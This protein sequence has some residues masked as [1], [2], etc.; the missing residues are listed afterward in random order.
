LNLGSDF[1]SS[2]AAVAEDNAIVDLVRSAVGGR[3]PSQHPHDPAVQ[4]DG[5]AGGGGG[6]GFRIVEVPGSA[7]AWDGATGKV[8]FSRQMQF[9]G[10]KGPWVGQKVWLAVLGWTRPNCERP[11]TG[12]VRY[13]EEIFRVRSDGST[14]LRGPGLSTSTPPSD[15]GRTADGKV[16]S[17]DSWE[18]DMQFGFADFTDDCDLCRFWVYFGAV[19]QDGCVPRTSN[20]Y[21]GG[22]LYDTSYYMTRD[23]RR[24]IGGSDRCNLGCR[25][26]VPSADPEGFAFWTNMIDCRCGA[27][28]R[29]SWRFHWSICPCR[30]RRRS[31]GVPEPADPEPRLVVTTDAGTVTRRVPPVTTPVPTYGVPPGARPGHEMGGGAFGPGEPPYPGDTSGPSVPRMPGGGALGRYEP[32][33]SRQPNLDGSRPMR[34]RDEP[35]LPVPRLPGESP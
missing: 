21:M 35:P 32:D 29:Y 6:G 7:K 18:Y 15:V 9:Q 10:A 27:A 3:S 33:P 5:A 31:P 4:A 22:G 20:M 11:D 25:T 13:I 14:D 19:A 8:G 16:W 28:L 26:N 17:S 24:S 23:V 1:A 2:A 12:C 30:S 34:H